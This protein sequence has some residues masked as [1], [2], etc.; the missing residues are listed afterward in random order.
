MIYGSL[1]LQ[2][3]KVNCFCS[4]KNRNEQTS[5]LLEKMGVFHFSKKEYT[6]LSL[7]E[8]LKPELASK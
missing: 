5:A 2:S 7:G 1:D 8:N 4:G 3:S 6:V